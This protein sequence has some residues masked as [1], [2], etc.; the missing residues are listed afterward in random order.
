MQFLPVDHLPAHAPVVTSEQVNIAG[1]TLPVLEGVAPCAIIAHET[2]RTF[3]DGYSWDDKRVS[4]TH[5]SNHSKYRGGEHLKEKRET[6]RFL[7]WST[8]HTWP[9]WW[10]QRYCE[11][12]AGLY[13]KCGPLVGSPRMNFGVS[14]PLLHPILVSFSPIHW[15]LKCLLW[16]DSLNDGFQPNR[17]SNT[18]L[19]HKALCDIIELFDS[20]IA[21]KNLIT[22]GD[23]KSFLF[24]SSHWGYAMVWSH[25]VGR[26]CLWGRVEI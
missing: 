5:E 20:I 17:I 11:V 3:V 2:F 7:G 25:V 14:C 8:Q 13:G 9:V 18:G 10:C 21:S 23:L 6:A 26:F 12:G 16:F 19:V 24:P 1:F 4:S 22:E 15:W